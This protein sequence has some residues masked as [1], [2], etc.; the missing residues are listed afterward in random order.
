M[1][2]EYHCDECGRVTEDPKLTTCCTNWDKR[3]DCPCMGKPIEV[4]CEDC[5]AL[6]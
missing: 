6:E 3:S 4:L 2:D 5:E 1:P